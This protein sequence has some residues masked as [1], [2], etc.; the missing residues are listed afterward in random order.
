MAGHGAIDSTFFYEL[1]KTTRSDVYD[2]TLILLLVFSA[3][4]L[5][6]KVVINGDL[7]TF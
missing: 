3:L 7:S 4:Y 6:F 1:H 5:F 2:L